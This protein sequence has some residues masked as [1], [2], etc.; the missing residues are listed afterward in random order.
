MKIPIISNL[1][2]REG[3]RRIRRVMRGYRFLK[4]SGNLGRISAVKAA[5]TNT[6]IEKC[7]S[8]VSKL[9]FGVGL[10]ESELITRQYLLSRV[11][12]LGLNKALLYA[13][14]KIGSSVVYPMPSEWRKVLRQHGFAVD[15]LLSATAWYF[16]IFTMYVKGILTIARLFFDCIKAI[17]FPSFLPLGKYAYFD[18]LT[19]GNLPQDLQDGRSYDVISWYQQWTGRFG[20][21]DTLCHS[22]K[23][24]APATVEAKPV[25]SVPAHV[26]PLTK[27][28]ALLRLLLWS[29]AATAR[30]FIDLFRNRWWHAFML[31]EAAKAAQVRL[32]SPHRLARVYL[33]H[34]S[35]HIYR[36][37]WTYEAAM[38]GSQITCYFYSINFE[39]FKRLG[40]YP[41]IP[42]GFHA[43]N[44][45]H[46]LT[47]DEYQ[48]SFV[49]SAVGLTPRI[50][51]VG[52]IP[53]NGGVKVP[54]G[55]PAGAIAIFDVQPMRD[56][57]YQTLGADFEYYV[58]KNA[59]KFLTDIQQ[60]TAMTARFMV[61]KPKRNIGRRL[62]PS[63]EGII[64]H[65]SKFSNLQEIDADTSAHAL[66][67]H[68]AAVVSA[69]FTSPAI[70]GRDLGKP[71]IY[72]DPNGIC[73]K[74]DRAAHGIPI[75]SGKA[76]LKEWLSSLSF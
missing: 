36:P 23:G 52:V 6:K 48:A 29:V 27:L 70:I 4:K 35:N 57:I 15:G 13:V 2:Q 11:G 67:A 46:Y 8:S 3:R 30:A 14:G 61:Y 43:M 21:L 66:I 16:F 72:Y 18:G 45:P 42:Y 49:R 47:W 74:D 22:V 75:L 69:P 73:E 32:Q 24:V 28:G 12:G 38:S 56:A 5:L 63:Y 26:P 37:L 55:I 59:N 60:S 44:W 39:P 25:I 40:G 68:C 9:I 31:M 76:E 62:H 50:D 58:P 1:L 64:N 17:I 54:H 53:F 51:I 34:L 7:G 33:F 71:S 65:L 19:V 20:D 10:N 41:P